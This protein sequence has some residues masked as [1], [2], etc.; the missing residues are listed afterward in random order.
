MKHSSVISGNCLFSGF[1]MVALFLSGGQVYGFA[2][3][4]RQAGM[5]PHKALY[6]VTMET[7][8][9]GSQVSNINGKMFYEWKTSCDAWISNH[10]FDVLYN[11]SDMPPMRIKSD[12]STYESF[13]GKSL[14]FTSQRKRGGQVFEELRGNANLEGE[15]GSGAAMFTLPPDLDIDLPEGTLFPMAHTLDVIDKINQG[16][17]F[18]KATVFDG[19]DKDG[20]VDI[21]TFIGKPFDTK[22]MAASLEKAEK[23]LIENKAWSLRLAF[24]PLLDYSATA[25]YEMDIVFHENGVISDMTIEYDDFSVRQKLVAIE[26]MEDSCGAEDKLQKKDEK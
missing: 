13:D 3:K 5:A 4:A 23:G 24:F 10:R 6:E 2:D 19:G 7:R 8:K 16:K 18:Y 26:P 25:D 17:K 21:N 22:G 1:L 11:Y 15:D 20:P 12:F 14:S 9:N